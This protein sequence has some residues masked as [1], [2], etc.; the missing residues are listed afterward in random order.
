MESRSRSPRRSVFRHKNLCVPLQGDEYAWLQWINRYHLACKHCRW[1]TR[2]WAGS[3]YLRHPYNGWWEWSY[4]LDGCGCRFYDEMGTELEENSFCLVK[5]LSVYGRR[6]GD[7]RRAA[8]FNRAFHGRLLRIDYVQRADFVKYYDGNDTVWGDDQG[9]RLGIEDIVATASL[10]PL[11]SAVRKELP[12]LSCRDCPEFIPRL[13]RL[14]DTSALANALPL[15]ALR[16]FQC[17]SRE[18]WRAV[19]PRRSDVSWVH[20]CQLVRRSVPRSTS[21]EI[22]AEFSPP[23]AMNRRAANPFFL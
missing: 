2:E 6:H 22:W 3:L 17:C 16:R 13:L 19:Q 1:E 15:M 10:R 23:K 8:E 18:I 12:R 20:A 11:L 9:P 14:R 21:V 5:P 4:D 7:R